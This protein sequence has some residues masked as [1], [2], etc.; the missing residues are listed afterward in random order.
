[1]KKDR[2]G[3][4]GGRALLQDPISMRF[5]AWKSGVVATMV[6]LRWSTKIVASPQGGYWREAAISE[7][8]HLEGKAR[9]SVVS[10]TATTL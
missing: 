7:H 10:V 3:A 1:M 9:G 2:N 6:R 4:G 8:G 5:G